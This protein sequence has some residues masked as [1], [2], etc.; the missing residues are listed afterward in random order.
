MHIILGFLTLL[1][2]LLWVYKNLNESG[3]K[4]S[5]INPFLWKRR[6]DW[7]KRRQ[8]NPLFIL[9]TPK[10]V[11][12]ALLYIVNRLDGELSFDEEE[13]LVED[14]Q[15][16]LKMSPQEAQATM[17]QTKFMLDNYP[18][19]I[20]DIDAI[21]HQNV[22]SQFSSAQVKSLVEHL[23]VIAGRKSGISSTQEEWIKKIK[24]C[25]EKLNVQSF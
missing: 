15:S 17:Q 9:D 22:L 6:H 23:G 5:S 1:G 25:F 21:F 8:M 24:Q 18:I 14:Y 19:V 16:I 4:L 7:N 3:F 11:A 13:I 20:S 12:A 10:D 2:T